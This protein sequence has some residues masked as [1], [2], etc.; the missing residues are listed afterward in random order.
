MTAKRGP[1]RPRKSETDRVGRGAQGDAGR[2]EIIRVGATVQAIA[3]IF[4][5]DAKIV[6]AKLAEAR[7]VPKYNANGQE[8]YAIREIAPYLCS[9]PMTGEVEK[10][11]RT[12]SLKKLP[13]ELTK[14]FWDAYNARKK[15]LEDDKHLWRTE[16]VMEVFMDAFSTLRQSVNQFVDTLSDHTKVTPEQHKAVVE[17]CD[18]LV[19]QLRH[20]LVDRFELYVPTEP[21]RYQEGEESLGPDDEETDEFDE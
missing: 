21:E 17:M 18:S 16:A 3:E 19:A 15:A 5:K 6:R 14:N 2:N 9:I 7:V 13:P 1:G 8:L 4:A 20:D 10:L 11:F 12:T